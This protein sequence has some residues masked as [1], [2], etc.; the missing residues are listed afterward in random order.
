MAL[1]DALQWLPSGDAQLPAAT[2]AFNAFLDA[3]S[4]GF[5]LNPAPEFLV[6]HAFLGTLVEEALTAPAGD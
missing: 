6:V 2:E 5:L 4:H 1:V 3:S